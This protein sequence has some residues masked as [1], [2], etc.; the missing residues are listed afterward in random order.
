MAASEPAQVPV[1]DL[2]DAVVDELLRRTAAGDQAAFNALYDRTAGRLFAVCLRIARHRRL[3]EELLREIYVGIWE[4]AREFDPA[5]GR[6][7]A[8]MT[9][10]ARTHAIDV[11]RI[12]IREP[13]PPDEVTLEAAEPTALGAME[14]RVE[15]DA[16]GRCLRELPYGE[17]HAL[18]LAYRDGLS[19]DQLAVLLGVSVETVK[20]WVSRGLAKLRDC[21]DKTP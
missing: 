21:M 2:D 8:W 12:K 7:L 1:K 9:S 11:I 3:A 4:R 16:V 13:R 10:I 5:R 17:R 6:A 18:V 14:A 19:Y 15:F 20:E